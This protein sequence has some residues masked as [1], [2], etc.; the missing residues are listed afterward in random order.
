M[1]ID[2]PASPTEGQVFIP[3]TATSS[4]PIFIYKSGKWTRNSGTANR[5]N[6]IVNPTM[7]IS[8]QNGNTSGAVTGYYP[9]D[10]WFLSFVGAYVN[11]FC[12]SAAAGPFTLSGSQYVLNFNADNG[13]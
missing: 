4:G 7:Q 8:Q 1:A 11:K 3:T 2:F 6:K 12:R 13:P 9:V 5:F 10:Q